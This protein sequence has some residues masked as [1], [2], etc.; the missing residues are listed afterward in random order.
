MSD[1]N[2]RCRICDH[3]HINPDKGHCYMFKEEMPNCKQFKRWQEIFNRLKQLEVEANL[4]KTSLP[5]TP[6][7]RSAMMYIKMYLRNN[8]VENAKKLFINRA[9]EI[10]PYTGLYS[11]LADLFGINP[12]ITPKKLYKT[13]ITIWSEESTDN[14]EL[15]QIVDKAMDGDM[16]CTKQECIL[17]DDL[18]NDEDW[19]GNTFFDQQEE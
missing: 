13:E 18:E 17:V 5:K 19:D 1:M 4:P 7:V 11:F 3:K 15:P 14:M 2:L 6:R 9:N 16:L 8:D 12:Y 10:H